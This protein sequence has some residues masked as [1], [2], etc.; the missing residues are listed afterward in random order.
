[1]AYSD[2]PSN[3]FSI[4]D[5]VVIAVYHEVTFFRR[6]IGK[7]TDHAPFSLSRVFIVLAGL[8]SPDREQTVKNRRLMSPPF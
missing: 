4:S 7:N 8:L 2:R 3:W 6:F 1:M 5:G